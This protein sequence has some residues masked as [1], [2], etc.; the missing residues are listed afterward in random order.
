MSAGVSTLVGRAA[1][2]SLA[3]L[4]VC[5]LLPLL[6]PAVQQAATASSWTTAG[7]PA[8]DVTAPTPAELASISRSARAFWSTA[9]PRLASNDQRLVAASTTAATAEVEPLDDATL[10]GALD[11]AVAAW[12]SAGHDVPAVSARVGDLPGND[13][14]RT[15]GTI[16][17]IDL[18][19][20]GHGWGGDGMDLA[21]VV[22][23]ELGHVLGYDHGAGVMATT[24]APGASHHDL[25]AAEHAS[26]G[27]AG[28][29]AGDLDE[30]HDHDETEAP[31]EVEGDGDGHGAAEG[32]EEPATG[33][34][35]VAVPAVDGDD[36]PIDG[37]TPD[38]DGAAPADP[39]TDGDAGTDGGASADGAQDVPLPDGAEVDVE[40]AE[41]GDGA[42]AAGDD[43]VGQATRPTAWAM[44]DG[45]AVARLGSGGALDHVLRIEGTR[46][47][48]VSGDGTM[49]LAPESVSHRVVGGDGDDVVRV[50]ASVVA[51]GIVVQVDG[52]LGHD[53]LVGPT[54]D[55]DWTI[56][57][58]GAG[59]FATVGFDGFEDLSG[60][61]DN[62]DTFFF[63][64]GGTLAG[65]VDGGVDGHDT[66]VVASGSFGRVVYAVT[67]PTSGTVRRDD[68]LVTYTGLEPTVDTTGGPKEF[69]GT[70]ISETITIRTQGTS[71]YVDIGIG[72][73]LELTNPAAVTSLTVRAGLGNNTIRIELLPATFAGALT[74]DG[75]IGDDTV[76]FAS[77]L[78]LAG[79]A[80]TVDA[81]AIVVE[82]G[83]TIDTR[84]RDATGATVGDSGAITLR[85]EH[86][87]LTGASIQA[88]A[89][90]ASGHAAGDVTIAAARTA[91]LEVTGFLPIDPSVNTASVD[92]A[93]STVNGGTVSITAA[94]EDGTFWGT[95]GDVGD[96]WLASLEDLIGQVPGLSLSALTGI[97][98]QISVRYATATVNLT[99]ATITAAGD[100]E[101]G[102]TAS[103]DAS[104]HTVSFNGV[105]AS[106]AFAISIAYGQAWST[107]TTTIE[108][109]SIIAVGTVTVYSS[110]AT[111]AFVKA[112]TAANSGPT[113]SG[114]A[115]AIA[116]AIA[117]TKEVAHT[118]VSAGSEVRSLEHSVA[119]T[120]DGEVTNFAWAQPNVSD[121]GTLAIAFAFDFDIADVKTVVD[122]RVDAAGGMDGTFS[123]NSDVDYTA[124][125]IRI[126]GHGF[127]DGEAVGYSP[128]SVAVALGD[129]EAPPISGLDEPEITW[130][131][132]YVD[133][134]TVRLARAPTIALDYVP[135]TGPT[136]T[137]RLSTLASLAIGSV[138]TANDTLAFASPH[139][140]ST[141][142]VV[143][144][145]GSAANAGGTL[146]PAIGG[147]TT[148]TVYVVEVVGAT[149]IR[150]REVGGGLVDL[151]TG[152]GGWTHEL[153]R[154]VAPLT[155]DPGTAVDALRNSLD[156][157]TPHGLSNGTAV[158]YRTDAARS[159]TVPLGPVRFTTGLMVVNDTTL[160]V[161]G[162]HVASIQV[163]K[164]V[165]LAVTGGTVMAQVV[166]ATHDAATGLT[167]VVVDLPIL[168]GVASIA[169]ARFDNDF[170]VVVPDAPIGDLE[171]G[172]LY[173]VVVVDVDTI[174]LVASQAAV[175]LAAPVDL[176]M[177]D[178]LDGTGLGDDHALSTSGCTAG[179]CI[180]ATLSATN[181]I[182][183]ASEIS[184]PSSPAASIA[185]G[186]TGGFGN[187]DEMIGAIAAIGQL[188][189]K[190][191][192]T[193]PTGS[194]Q[195]FQLAGA[196]GINYLVHTVDVIVGCDH[197][198]TPGCTSHAQIT[199]ASGIEIAASIEQAAQVAVTSGATRCDTGTNGSCTAPAGSGSGTTIGVAIAVGLGLFT[200]TARVTVKDGASLDAHDGIVIDS[201]VAYGFLLANPLSAINPLD[202]L[203]NTGP[204]GWAYF[205]DGTL[206]FSSN[207]FN[208]W[209]MTSASESDV[210]GGVSFALNSYTN[211]AT[212][213]IASGARINQ[214]TLPTYTS[215]DQGVDV[216]AGITM[217]L[218]GIV[219]VG[220]LSLSISGGIGSY[221]SVRDAA[222]QG[223]GRGGQALE[224]IKSLVN[225]FGAEGGKA[226]IGASIL[227]EVFSNTARAAI[228]S[229]A[230]IRAGPG[231]L[232]VTS[233]T[234]IFTFAL[235]QAG[236]KGST[237]GLS[238]AVTV[239]DLTNT[240]T[241]IIG[242]GARVTS[243]GTLSVDAHDTLDRIA[244]AGAVS[245][246]K[247]IGAGVS[248]G[249]NLVDR[250]TVAAIG[251]WDP[252]TATRIDP[253]LPAPASP[254]VITVAD[255]VTIAA[256]S[257]GSIV[258][259]VL[260]GAIA[261]VN[262]GDTNPQ[263]TSSQPRG[264]DLS[265][266]VTVSVGVNIVEQNSVLAYVDDVDV[267][268]GGAIAVGATT[269]PE[270]LAIVVALAVKIDK[271]SGST[272]RS[273][274][275]S[276]DLSIAGA[277]AV[278][279]VDDDVRAFASDTTLRGADVS[280]AAIHTSSV[281]ADAGGVAIMAFIG[282]KPGTLSAAV[283][284]SVAINTIVA[285]VTATLD[286]AA[287]HATGAVAVTASAAPT[288]QALT[289]AGAINVVVG[290]GSGSASSGA[291]LALTGGGAG[292]GNVVVSTVK[293][294]VQDATV[295]AGGDVTVTAD[296]T[297]TITADAGGV[298]I[299]VTV[300]PGS[301]GSGADF[302]V[303][304]GVAVNRIGRGDT[305]TG[306]QVS[307]IVRG[308]TVDA[309]GRV[310]VAATS[311]ATIDALTFGITVDIDVS[312]SS[313]LGVDGSLG[314]SFNTIHES[315][316]LATIDQSSTVT[317]D[318]HVEVHATDTSTIE[319]DAG[320]F[321]LALAIGDGSGLDASVGV[322]VAIN[323]I[324]GTGDGDRGAVTALIDAS[325][326]TGG[327]GVSVV[328]TST[329]V[330]DA[331]TLGGALNG[332][333][334][335]GS[336]VELAGGGA[337]AKNTIRVDVLAT[338]RGSSTA[339]G[340][341]AVVTATTGSVRVE[342]SDAA[343][344]TA[345]AGGFAIVLKIGDGN[346]VNAAVGVAVAINDIA[347]TVRAVVSRAT[348][349]ADSVVV[350][351][352]VPVTA[353]VDS[354]VLGGAGGLHVG[355]G[356]SN[357]LDLSAGV[358][359]AIN[360]IANVVAAI[361]E[362]GASVTARTGAVAVTAADRAMIVADA[363]GFALTI[364]VKPA[365]GNGAA[366]SAGVSVANNTITTDVLA[367]VRSGSVTT[368]TGSSTGTDVFVRATSTA[369]VAALSVSVGGSVSVTVGSGVGGAV[370]VAYAGA[371]NRLAGT[372]RAE[373]TSLA[374]G[375]RSSVTADG[376]IEVEATDTATITA[377]YIVISAAVSIGVGK[378]GSGAGAVSIT[379]AGNTIDRTVE[380]LVGSAT[381]DAGGAVAI[382]ATTSRSVTVVSTSVGVTVAL[383]I[384]KAPI[385]LGITVLSVETIN[386]VGGATRARIAATAIV[387]SRG[388]GIIVAAR[389]T[390]TMDA[391][392]D[393]V[394]VSLALL[395]ATAVLVTA[396]N[397]AD[398]ELA[399]TVAGT[400]TA[401]TGTVDV[402]ATSMID[403]VRT[404]ALSVAVAIGI[405]GAGTGPKITATI[406]GSTIA[407]IDGGAS[408][409]AHGAVTVAANQTAMLEVIANGGSGSLIVADILEATGT[410]ER[411]VRAIIARGGSVSAASLAVTAVADDLDAKV[412]SELGNVGVAG[413]G[414]ALTVTATVSSDVEA[415]VGDETGATGAGAS[416]IDVT[417]A[418]LIAA[419]SKAATA[420]ADVR[421]GSGSV[422][423][424]VTLMSATAEVTGTTTARLGSLGAGSF[425]V[426]SLQVVADEQDRLADADL[427]IVSVGLLGSGLG[428]EDGNLPV[429]A[430]VDG[431]ITAEVAPGVAVTVDGAVIVDATGRA[432]ADAR[433]DGG[434]GCLGFCVAI[435][436]VEASNDLDVRAGIAANA[437]LS[438]GSLSIT[439]ATAL[440]IDGAVIVGQGAIIGGGGRAQ[441]DA[442]ASGAV[443]AVVG[444]QAD[445]TLAG[446][447]VL[448]EAKSDVRG[449]A[450]VLIATG[451]LLVGGREAKATTDLTHTTEARIGERATVVVRGGP[452]DDAAD[453]T[454]RATSTVEGDAK[455]QSYGGA[456]LGDGGAA[457]A[458]TTVTPVVLATIG[459][460]SRLDV[461]GDVTLEAVFANTGSAPSAEVVAIDPD[462]E[463][464]TV[465]TGLRLRDGDIVTFGNGTL[466]TSL[467]SG[468]Q[469]QVLVVAPGVVQLGSMLDGSSI[470]ATRDTIT[471]GGEHMFATGDRVRV[472]A[473]TL[474][475][476][477]PA[478]NVDDA[479]DSIRLDVRTALRTGDAV[480]Y[481]NADGVA[482]GGLVDGT[483]YWVVV[484]PTD[485]QR[486]RLAASRA[487]AMAAVPVV[488]DLTAT[489]ESGQRDTFIGVLDGIDPATTYV[490]S[491]V[492][493]RTIKLL[494]GSEAPSLAFTG[495]DV[496]ADTITIVG[497]GFLDG[498]HVTY[499]GPGGAI[500]FSWD[501]VDAVTTVQTIEGRSV[502]I[503]K[504]S[505]TGDVAVDVD[506]DTIYVGPDHGLT[507]GTVVR[508]HAPT[509]GP[510]IVGLVNGQDYRVIVVTRPGATVS[511]EVQLAAAGS[512]TAVRFSSDFFN[513][514]AWDGDTIR[515]VD[516]QSWAAFGFAT[517]QVITIAGSLGN[518]GDW[519]ISSVSGATLVL[520]T[521]NV[522]LDTV[523]ADDVIEVTSG[524]IAIDRL[525]T[526]VT[527]TSDASNGLAYDNDIV[528]RAD[529]Q[530]W[531]AFGFAAGQRVFVV[532]SGANSDT[533]VIRRLDGDVMV[534]DMKNR[535]VDTVVSEQVTISEIGTYSITR[536]PRLDIGGL[537]DGVTYYVRR[538]DDDE[539][540]LAA[541]PGGAPLAL[542]GSGRTLT[543]FIGTTGIDLGPGSGRHAVVLDL[544]TSTGTFDVLGPEGEDL[545]E[546]LGT[547]GDGQSTAIALGG[548][549]ALGVSASEPR[550][551]ITVSPWVV[552][553][554]GDQEA[555]TEACDGSATGAAR[556]TVVAA[557]A[558]TVAA[559]STAD[560][561]TNVDVR[562]G[563]I[564]QVGVARSK[565]VLEPVTLAIVGTRSRL[566][567]ANVSVVATMTATL[568][569]TT[570]AAG[571]GVVAVSDADASGTI[572]F[573]TLAAFDSDTDVTARDG[574][575]G[576]ATTT[577]SGTV[578]ATSFAAGGAFWAS[579][580]ANFD[581]ISEF[582]PAGL[583]VVGQS[584]VLVASG[585]R[586]SAETVSLVAR[587]PHLSAASR[588]GA[589][590]FAVVVFLAV[591]KAYAV[592]NT[593]VDVGAHVVV[594]SGVTRQTLVEGRRGVDLRALADSV[595]IVRRAGRL[596]VG[597]IPP[598][599]AFAGPCD[600]TGDCKRALIFYTR[601]TIWVGTGVDVGAN[602]H[603][604]AGARDA[605]ASALAHPQTGGAAYPALALFVESH[606]G[607]TTD[608]PESWKV[609]TQEGYFDDHLSSLRTTSD[610]ILDGD[611]TILGG[612]R[613]APTLV[614]DEAGII[615]AA[616]GVQIRCDQ[617]I[618]GVCAA[619][620]L[621]DATVGT[622]V[623]P[624]D[625]GS[626]RVVVV[627]EGG[628]NVLVAADSLIANGG[629][630]TLPWPLWTFADTLAGVTIVDHSDV[631]L[632]IEG[633]DVVAPATARP[634]V[635][636]VTE[637]DNAD[638]VEP[639]TPYR[640]QFDL[641]RTAG[642][643]FVDVQK[644]GNAILE[645]AGTIT[646]PTGWTHLLAVLSDIEG[647]T[648]W[649]VTNVAHIEA[650]AGAIGTVTR[651]QVK[652]VQSIDRGRD[653][654]A[655]GDDV[656]R[657]T[658][659]HARA[660]GD[661]VLR[662]W[663]ADRV[664][665]SHPLNGPFVVWIDR[666][667]SRAGDVD[668]DLLDSVREHGSATPGA[669]RVIVFDSQA[670][671]PGTSGAPVLDHVYTDHF[672]PDAGGAVG[673]DPGAYATS[674]TC[675]ATDTTD[676]IPSIYRFQQRGTFPSRTTATWSG[677]GLAWD[678][679][680]PGVRV[681]RD[682][683][684]PGGTPV[685]GLVAAGH[686]DVV[687]AGPDSPLLVIVGWVDLADAGSGF[688]TVDTDGQVHITETSGDL[689]VGRIR[690]RLARVVLAART[691]G[692]LDADPSDA[693][694]A[695]DPS[696][697]IGVGITLHALAGSIGTEADFLEIDLIGDA[698]LSRLNA[699]A[700]GQVLVTETAG[701]LRVGLVVSTQASGAGTT[702]VALS[703]RAGSILDGLGDD[704]ADVV[705]IRIDLG[706]FGGG[707]G[708]S[709][710]DLGVNSSSTATGSLYLYA[711]G[712]IRVTE[713]AGAMR[714]LAAISTQGLVRLTIPDTNQTRAPPTAAGDNS[715]P[716]DLLLLTQGSAII[717][718]GD[719]RTIATDPGT[720]PAPTPN[721]SGIWAALDISLWIGD[722]LLAPA[723]SWIVAGGT[724]FIHGDVDRETA[725]PT[726]IDPDPHG[727]PA[728]TNLDPG[729]T[730][731]VFAGTLGGVFDAC[732][733]GIACG[734][735]NPTDLVRIFGNTETDWVTFD[736]TLL[737]A[738]TR[739]YGSDDL[740]ATNEP[741]GDGDD[742]VLVDRLRSTPHRLTIDGQQGSDFT[743]VRTTGSQGDRRSYVVN[744]LDTGAADDGID[745]LLVRG[746]DLSDD[747][748][749]LRGASAIAGEVSDRPAFVALLHDDVADARCA[750]DA[751]PACTRPGEV[752][753]IN[754]DA[755][756]DDLTGGVEVRG[757]AGD[758]TFASDDTSAPVRLDGGVGDDTFQVGQLYGSRRDLAAVVAVDRFPT[759][760]T[761]RGW[762]S[763]GNSRAMLAA[764]GAGD[765]VFQ[766]YANQAPL[767]LEGDAGNDLFTVRAFA[768][769]ETTGDC[770]DLASTTCAVVW[771]DE[772][773]RVAMPVLVGAQVQYVVNEVV[774]IDGGAGFDKTVAIATEFGDHL[775]VDETGVYGA[776]LTVSVTTIEALE[777]DAMEGDDRIDVVGTAAGLG[778][779]VIGG[780][781]SDI[782]GVAG[783][784][785]DDVV[786][787]KSFPKRAHVL[788]VLRGPLAVEGGETGA[789]R[790]L[791]IALLLPGE[792]N[793]PLFAIAAQ[794]T[795][796]EQVD[797]LGV[798]DDG[799]PVGAS[800]EL[801]ATTV[802]GFGMAG[803]LTFASTAFGES[804]T[805]PGG[806]SFAATLVAGGVVTTDPARTTLE[807]VSLLLGPGADALL[808]TGSVAP[809][810]DLS[811][812]V[813]AA[814]GGLTVVHA[815]GGGDLV[816]VTG[817]GGPA[818]PLVL[819][820]DTSQDGRWYGGSSAAL[821][822]V[823]LGSKPFVGVVGSA[824]TFV[825]GQAVAFTAPGNDTIDAAATGTPGAAIGVIAFG[826]PGDDTLVGSVA[827]DVLA[828]GSGD[829]R[830]EG[831]AGDDHVYG[832]SGIDVDVRSRLLTV[833]TVN[834]SAQPNAD[835][836]VAG[837]DHLLGGAGHD[838][839]FGD[840][841][842]VSQD[843][844]EATVG[845]D[846]WR[847]GLVLPQRI[848]TTR[849][850]V[851]LATVQPLNGAADRIEG[852]AGNDVV[853][854]GG[855]GDTVSG[856]SGNDLVFGDFG[857]VDRTTAFVDEALPLLPL[858]LPVAMHPITWTSIDTGSDRNGAD[859]LLRAD[860]GDDVVIGG[861]GGDRITGGDGDDDIV[862]GHNVAGG[863]DGDDV[864]D[865]GAGNDV[866]AGDNANLLR[867]GTTVGPRMRV[868][869]GSAIFA[870]ETG[871]PLVTGE[872]QADPRG[873]SVRH[874]TLF[875]HV[876]G[877]DPATF[878]DDVLAGGADDDVL[879]G[880]LGDDWLQGDGATIDDDGIVVL[881]VVRT[882]VSVEDWAG[883]GR[884][885]DDWIEGNGGNDTIFGNLGQD[886]LVGDN[887]SLFSLVTRA[888]REPVGHDTIFGGG[889]TRLVR[890]DS[891][892]CGCDTVKHATDA[893]VILGDN[894]D[895][896]RLVGTFGTASGDFLRFNHD[897]SGPDRW[898]I[899]RAHRLLDYTQGGAATDLG[900][901]DLLHGERGDDTLHG[902]TGD[903]VVF[904]EA[905]D[906]D[907]YGG[908]GNDR[909]YGGS[910]VDGILG[911]DG[912]IL[913]SRNGR[914]EPLH[915]LATPNAEV[916][917]SVPGPFIGTIEYRTGALTKAVDLAAWES[918]GAD[919]IYGGIGDDF[920]HGGA[921]DDA[922]SG[923]EA[924]RDFYT[925]V[926]QDTALLG[927]DPADP[928]G[929]DPVTR[930]LAAYD[931]DDPRT[932]IDGFL[933][934]FDPWIV[935]E[936]TGLP[937]VTVSGWVPRD[938]G[939][940]RIFGDNG[941]D[942]LVG[943]TNYDRLF[944]GLGDDLLDADDNHD[945]NGGRNDGP[946]TD[947]TP[948]TSSWFAQGDFAFG[949][950][951]L[952]VLIANT[953][954]D[955]LFDWTGEFNSFIVP[956]SPFGSPTVNRRFSPATRDFL[957]DL[958]ATSG[959][960]TATLAEPYDE[961]AVVEPGDDLWG[962]QHGG[963]RDPQPGNLPGVMRDDVGG[964]E[965]SLLI[966]P[967]DITLLL[968]DKAINALQPL[969]P[970]GAE[971][972]DTA[973][974]RRLAEGD[975]VVWT[976]L[977][978][979]HGTGAV[980]I[981]GIVD[982]NGTPDDPSDDFVPV[983]VSGDTD[984]DGLLDP[985]ET[986][987]YTSAGVVTYRAVP[988]EYANWVRVTGVDTATGHALDASDPNH[989]FV[990]DDP[991]PAIDVQKAI[992]AAD[993]LAP[994][995]TEDA[996]AVAVVLPTGT[997]VV[998]TYLVRNDADVALDS[999]V[1000]IDDAGTPSD[1001]TDDFVPR[1002]VVDVSGFNVGDLDRDGRLD[1003]GETWLFT[1004]EG[1005]WM[1006][1007]ASGAYCN[1008]VM[1009]TARDGTAVLTG[1010]DPNCH[1011][1012]P[1013]PPP[1014]PVVD[1015]E[1016]AVNAVD[1017]LAPTVLEDADS[1018]T[1019]APVLVVG[1020]V[1021]TFTYV[1022]TNPGTVAVAV[1023]LVDDNATP[1024]PADDFM[1025]VLVSGDTDGDGLLDPGE[1026]WLFV[1027]TAT[1028]QEGLHTN[1029]A[1030]VTAMDP[1031]TGAE[1032][1033]DRDPANY[1034]GQVPPPP[1035]SIT[1036]DK[1037]LVVVASGAE[1038]DAA[1039]PGLRLPVGTV[1040]RWTY[1041]VSLT[1042]GGPVSEVTVVDDN[1043]TPDDLT[1044]DF[1045]AVYVS[1046][1047]TDGDGLLDPGE[1048]W[1049][1050]RSGEHV[1051]T[1052][1053]VYRNVAEVSASVDGWRVTARDAAQHEGTVAG[1054]DV[1055][1056]ALDPAD[1057]RN[1058]TEAEDADTG[1059][1060]PALL[1061]GTAITWSYLVT[1062]TGTVE[1063][1064]I[1065]DIID[1066][1067]GTPDDPTDDRRPVYVSGDTDGDG[1068]L[1069]PGETWRFTLDG[1070]VGI[1071]DYVNEVTV[1072]AVEAVPG[1073]VAHDPVTDSDRNHHRGVDEGETGQQGLT[1074][1075]FW[1076]NNARHHDANQWTF[1077]APE[1078]ALDTLFVV[1079]ASL[1080]LGSVTLVDSLDL[1081]GGVAAALLRHAVAAVLN[1082]LHPDIAYPMTVSEIVAE[1083]NAAL[1084]SGDRGQITA[1085]KDRLDGFNNLGA[1086][1087]SQQPG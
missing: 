44:E 493:D 654:A 1048:V 609:W 278:N 465:D 541:T 504:V 995:S 445:L 326:V 935:D 11:E 406:G 632:V 136:S 883:P 417:G 604:V 252:V 527:W 501:L 748:F 844:E 791:W 13:L 440:Q 810:V 509:G 400:L 25:P 303:G 280:V 353:T 363:G 306:N 736:A 221:E 370:G 284:V 665:M 1017:P 222:K 155:F 119:I 365:G 832:D 952:D 761:T 67:G 747:V 957:R 843:V 918:G 612:R 237:L 593:F 333:I 955:R 229:G 12:S 614:V 277:V 652:L 158:V 762:L 534:L 688:V 807:V 120:A 716:E 297:S 738:V 1051:V 664:P 1040:V 765:D 670:G 1075:G 64:A 692:I 248:I 683:T 253:S 531:S 594:E 701:D 744:V 936:A 803:P 868:L 121:S 641:R 383:Q 193:V 355:T 706:A 911:D 141:G 666:V 853:L 1002:P 495:A 147:M 643:P 973:P 823:D 126:L 989:H 305:D 631:R 984:G 637:R 16:I 102:A 804:A 487:D 500:E 1027:A 469:Y 928:L 474:G 958:G 309:G 560:V 806:I 186:L 262:A 475:G 871:E 940:D 177:A 452:D 79:S 437:H 362:Q 533:Y 708:S 227:V 676:C 908:T 994:T 482:V 528:R 317:A 822:F 290:G 258:A 21:T 231:G 672:L 1072:I 459:A 454:I 801:G 468:R 900:R 324:G 579:A 310:R 145:I 54:G 250:S 294:R 410:V 854:A 176:A 713:T 856:G 601:G 101:V 19:A 743:E 529:G 137:H 386:R 351:A 892:G 726:A 172:G 364:A 442:T 1019:A 1030:T 945:T 588:A 754:Y 896:F 552:A 753:R 356:N 669:V 420:T 131:V 92:I 494:T 712:P 312:S 721:R 39:S 60:A 671:I 5:L 700:T 1053:G 220:G 20:A 953:A 271:P 200:N 63:E 415:R 974:G 740:S 602:V 264:F 197:L 56:S 1078:Q 537:V 1033:D 270:L 595:S 434:A 685:A 374:G 1010:S 660:A 829:D 331:L 96:T 47:A 752:Q 555:T 359:V 366:V 722:D 408:V 268:T 8:P 596:A 901:S 170:M 212:A 638:P 811:T 873:A 532:G 961:V 330:I 40:P 460:S 565:G 976:Y 557:G 818:S 161:A 1016:K 932:R 926:A 799:R 881:D 769:A 742:V 737:G 329:Q 335:G 183:A 266:A 875:D 812:G 615:R 354:L 115:R 819:Y 968:V 219:G 424:A 978:S 477:D 960:D 273:G 592:A 651:L 732:W 546:I 82:S 276:V 123:A 392:V 138:T 963:P 396:T 10:A 1009:V 668:L 218:I 770:D 867:T 407:R 199:S 307:A 178:D 213:T 1006:H 389:D 1079:P 4:A 582:T 717:F 677:T 282:S 265:A 745:R 849:R 645:V 421:G 1081:D 980:Q 617:A 322:G 1060:G 357:S 1036:I 786:S 348:V 376:D 436:D 907:L 211:T 702:D 739:V 877:A 790:S 535:V 74:I 698:P 794:P 368:G 274:G 444:D 923:A 927:Y 470:D 128:G 937:I 289:I 897:L 1083:V 9:L 511:A 71:L 80:V 311:S 188:A 639:T 864:V 680:D 1021:V 236:G 814:H 606:V 50:D 948:D 840:H 263:S 1013:P 7:P 999:I 587:V 997:Q 998:W 653:V 563:G 599:G 729:G 591:T 361:V 882:G 476:F 965:L 189:T 847:R 149:T 308:S 728:G 479:A 657:T 269:M 993:P 98:G 571:G 499:T 157:A 259:V 939:R 675:T 598:Q 768:L 160:T 886:D 898:I 251:G 566:E 240:T 816:T 760:A 621:R 951:G 988:G 243:G 43:E 884:D 967:C 127:A 583:K 458:T 490:V 971:D 66:L 116:I 781:G 972:A 388:T 929:H 950:G 225:P 656:L 838:L 166:S 820:G 471:F 827:A 577:V 57:G 59:R 969:V 805:L 895:I 772:A 398:G 975:V 156:F 846:G 3:V 616:N 163:G 861:Q 503:P 924:T 699:D 58:S 755:G 1069:D 678:A 519:T 833:P 1057:W 159:T 69:D 448:V 1068:R 411:D 291:T 837:R 826:G 800:G 855:A 758:D 347:N 620:Q 210:S 860:G 831:R 1029:L 154:E 746:T 91:V 1049:V 129:V 38:D 449:F 288:I 1034:V 941:H 1037:R 1070:V 1023:S 1061:P 866:V 478:T 76:V 506:L 35:A 384:S 293:A 650:V 77:N 545:A 135:P 1085:L 909:L 600:S 81:E 865:A 467:V 1022:V 249:I 793:G 730:V 430:R 1077:L 255:D 689:R 1074:P 824:P 548:S 174:R 985:G 267:T 106:G 943:G 934:A 608:K 496:A 1062:N 725:S 17:T 569:V 1:R 97:G 996:D 72:E 27:G 667:E 49:D 425:D 694:D 453:V 693:A 325:T 869:V 112:R 201:A 782:V 28:G 644:W 611:V 339:G 95:V 427:L 567:G 94:A 194:S 1039:G 1065:I 1024:D 346:G 110:A 655:T 938:D 341:R 185:G 681:S 891:A 1008:R 540:Q 556:T 647:G 419:T 164:A 423:I 34:E 802:T 515:R 438:A 173:F 117:H 749:L 399:S 623:D 622:L 302:L 778:T 1032:A 715:T 235:A 208:T 894:G 581:N 202:Y 1011:D 431:D 710:F 52:G 711:T 234:D 316:T 674:G 1018:A 244:I 104:I 629:R 241:A 605:A 774:E 209:V 338:I 26:A 402:S 180:L 696:D 382:R 140:F 217:N 690:S 987:L 959:A 956:F 85:G 879:F 298:A 395:A 889:G 42:P 428:G 1005:V 922:I 695:T 405:A 373:I 45:V 888:Q 1042:E 990:P 1026:V 1084:A 771:R 350:R 1031:T 513:G 679:Y 723:G 48:L 319:A 914:N 703:A 375:A 422:L 874:V 979:H 481:R 426:G 522:I 228:E 41:L 544:D 850:V 296:D 55:V 190:K 590:S 372:V 916:L 393:A 558:I 851:S 966:D 585:A 179:V 1058:P 584:L 242:S 524:V 1044:D 751:D 457:R 962:D 625:N 61:A 1041:A 780:L 132:Q 205:N 1043:G 852:G 862:G 226:G 876:L 628:A 320:G 371:T 403:I 1086:P 483:T 543:H 624:D 377:T 880:Q 520:T 418:F 915:R 733:T 124:N 379:V 783:D 573:L 982:D 238:G 1080:G 68:D 334:G 429:K 1059:P 230:A 489:T 904:G 1050:F 1025:P 707:I 795:E 301:G 830:I 684:V 246:A 575:V 893:D 380:G 508:Y 33:Q 870:V 944:G 523:F 323:S 125:T 433:A 261:G 22:R 798:Y 340:P 992:N 1071:G 105:A 1056:K 414:I 815:G 836:L 878:G 150:L 756:L 930:M 315:R 661:V 662:L 663:A 920:L 37:E 564:V 964:P 75:G 24:L 292:S 691:G 1067:N 181:A 111:N 510:A 947:A 153:V 114:D 890:N 942:W 910:G 903:D 1076:K 191:S 779:R 390:T 784:V 300:V 673:L 734:G 187:V 287:V 949:G 358:A 122:G 29:T 1028:V 539:F 133:A 627:N 118:I 526:S 349:T 206:G 88:G 198:V 1000:L 46:L 416:V 512:V 613:G 260:G 223:A 514:A 464:V 848:E 461:D 367:T 899:P 397:T 808:V 741:A 318:Q 167:T 93:N 484:D 53:R 143:T 378:G 597:L 1004:S 1007:T 912:K 720:T 902:M 369:S 777:V 146:G 709:A 387:T 488:I 195:T 576:H 215:G 1014:P 536:L 313:G 705:A 2:W 1003:P 15:D 224:G 332:Q 659:L 981:T 817:G 921:G 175:A 1035:T 196:V 394:G 542:D 986:W 283:G 1001:P 321:S 30:S 785:V 1046:G 286:G 906:D 905:G 139:G 439:A 498:Q 233:T 328:A 73:D 337:G 151:T 572:D 766:V 502:P 767:R 1066:D 152:T 933:L 36:E 554:V 336:G 931:P 658:Q 633:I 401:T 32:T 87:T 381:L 607:T 630:A 704:R 466:P 775:V 162:D 682:A 796:R 83:V 516:G 492:D 1038:F 130:Y 134:D 451:N 841:G 603:I 727:T 472:V 497:H 462:A 983:L 90:P 342:A 108:R 182:N 954:A 586:L 463:T 352:H 435:I 256:T 275:F 447:P 165:T 570:T 295:N 62:R 913:T 835:P 245:A 885:G 776:G 759:T 562:S 142:D 547:G 89:D 314:G 485:S 553:C 731:M 561:Y 887:S 649:V 517:G 14:G 1047:D 247:Q 789:D 257:D 109:S 441:A 391:S 1015:V 809:A 574:I 51:A 642:E 813:V 1012:V 1064:V 480:V 113:S 507:T 610:A 344:I 345:D 432:D 859:D 1045:L 946:E 686:L 443:T 184:D 714:L 872:F 991:P 1052:R 385:S 412:S 919:V 646:N 1054:I 279:E 773:G 171:D 70:G 204:D 550:T 505:S 626:Y 640:L 578:E 486:I 538:L 456:I 281:D 549:G 763:R 207:L 327:T 977:V 559:E 842:S 1020:D 360:T 925:D 84:S 858:N 635:W 787:Q 618:A 764:G 23:H 450:D 446:G 735:A 272:A 413:S 821:S 78:A 551:T 168:A 86:V 473:R 169:E 1073:P 792:R 619:G 31:V 18:T 797:L 232:A 404:R 634:T 530:N 687:H 285:H 299:A 1055:E 103:T 203:R 718:Q 304:I 580:D 192:A 107:A 724:I 409:T 845:P 99:D 216:S 648:G 518:D 343:R 525:R 6:P 254:V 589:E 839:V 144:Y 970:T 65:V 828:G 521:Q 750:V 568:K 719:V 100:A 148:G 834:S 917:L 636:L 214:S 239:A 857:R 455:A 1082:A 863:Q 697:V 491:V 825:V 1063:L 1087:V 757:L 788:T